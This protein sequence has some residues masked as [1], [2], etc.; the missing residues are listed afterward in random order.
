MRATTKGVKRNLY[1]EL[2]AGV[3][4]MKAHRESLLALKSPRVEPLSVP[5]ISPKRR[6]RT[7]Q[8]SSES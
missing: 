4:A 1:G 6:N 7:A 5:A 2:M 3:R 8:R